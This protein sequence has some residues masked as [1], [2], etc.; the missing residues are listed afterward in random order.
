MN[1]KKIVSLHAVLIP[2]CAALSS[3]LVVADGFSYDLEEKIQ[4]AMVGRGASRGR[5]GARWEGENCVKSRVLR[6]IVDRV[7]NKPVTSPVTGIT[8]PMAPGFSVAIR[9]PECGE[10]T[11][12]VGHRDIAARKRLTVNTPMWSGSMTKLLASALTLRLIEENYF[13]NTNV[14]DVLN[15]KVDEWLTLEQIHALKVGNDLATPLCVEDAS[16]PNLR[17]S[18]LQGR[19]APIFN[20]VPIFCPDL[21]QISLRELLNANHGMIDFV[22]EEIN[23]TLGLPRINDL[24][25]D[26]AL[27]ALGDDPAGLLQRPDAMENGFDFLRIA[28]IAKYPGATIGGTTFVDT[29]TSL[30]NTGYQLVGIIL[31]NLTGESLTRLFY[32]FLVAPLGLDPIIF[33]AVTPELHPICEWLIERYP[34]KERH[35]AK[36][37][38]NSSYAKAHRRLTL[39]YIEELP[40]QVYETVAQNGHPL[41]DNKQLADGRIEFIAGFGAAGGSATTPLSYAKF[42]DAFVNG[43]LLSEQSKDELFGPLDNDPSTPGSRYSLEVTPGVPSGISYSLGVIINEPG[44]IPEAPE[45][46]RFS[47]NGGTAAGVCSNFVFEEPSK[48]SITG[49]ICMNGFLFSAFAAGAEPEA[50]TKELFLAIRNND[51]GGNVSYDDFCRA[52]GISRKD[53]SIAN[54]YDTDLEDHGNPASQQH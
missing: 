9:S 21:S 2:L 44:H 12:A 43:D 14:N 45:V 5:T 28:G 37:C 35:I 7:Y 13:G 46:T 40:A 26:K 48:P 42:L 23:F 31:E 36:K 20:L 17:T 32:K 33:P 41:V 30:G 18:F 19:D 16:G 3:N 52:A 47:H 25:F 27:I 50:L 51:S 8:A 34:E 53:Q 38:R 6:K 11:Y 29:E 4:S 49:V 15:T 54:T 22:A 1:G 39:G 24:L 10:F